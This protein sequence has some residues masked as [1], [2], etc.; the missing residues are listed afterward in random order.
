MTF[1][2]DSYEEAYEKASEIEDQIID[3]VF[4]VEDCGQIDIECLDE[5]ELDNEEE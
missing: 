2:A 4:H 5:E 3:Q 1:E